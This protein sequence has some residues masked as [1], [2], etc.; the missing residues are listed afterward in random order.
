MKISYGGGVGN[1]L[2][3]GLGGISTLGGGL[4]MIAGI[5][6]AVLEMEP[7]D[8]PPTPPPGDPIPIPNPAPQ[9]VDVVDP[10]AGTVVHPVGKKPDGVSDARAQQWLSNDNL[11]A[12]R[13]RYDFTVDRDTQ[14]LWGEP[15]NPTY[16]LRWGQRVDN[17][18]QLRRSGMR[19]PN[20]WLMFFN[21]LVVTNPPTPVKQ[22]PIDRNIGTPIGN[23]TNDGG[24]AAA[25]DGDT[26]QTWLKSPTGASPEGVT[27]GKGFPT[28]HIITGVKI[29]LSS[30]LG[31]N[32]NDG[33]IRTCTVYGK[34]G[35]DPISPPDGSKLHSF[36]VADTAGPVAPVLTGFNTSIAYDR[37]WA[38]L[39]N[40]TSDGL[41]VFTEIEW[42]ENV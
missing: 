5:L 1:A 18:P 33:A 11:L 26:G 23:A 28:P 13:G 39:E 15:V 4:G 16:I 9:Q 32:A 22:V 41:S 24:L 35:S 14:I 3:A 7:P 20:F 36:T 38:T 25:Y 40:A 2:L 29:W 30:N 19:F 17:D 6:W 42:Y 21:E 10:A 8:Y 27:I 34:N 37:V 12:G 31:F